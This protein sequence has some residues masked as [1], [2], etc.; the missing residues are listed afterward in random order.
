MN[1]L[2]VR[3][4]LKRLTEKER[5]QLLP[6]MGK[7]RFR[8]L[9]ELDD[10]ALMDALCE[11]TA[12]T[13]VR[14]YDKKTSGLSPEGVKLLEERKEQLRSP[15]NAIHVD[16]RQIRY[17]ERLKAMRMDVPELFKSRPEPKQFYRE[18][19]RFCRDNDIPEA[20][21]QRLVPAIIHYVETG[22]M[23]PVILVGEK[24]C[25]KTTALRL[26][27]EKALKLP[28]T[29]VKVPQLDG[30][31]GMTGDCGMYRSADAGCLAK[32][33]L[34]AGTL[35]HAFIFDEI[36]KV[37][38]DGNR[39]AV[40]DELLSV[41]DESC[42]DIFDNY[43]ETTLVGL[44]HCP[45]FF[46]ANDLNKVSP[47]LADRCEI[48]RF[49]NADAERIK[50]ISRKYVDKKMES[51]LYDLIRFDYELMDRHID[52][53]VRHNV[54]S[55]RKHQQMIEAVL[56]KVLTDALCS[57]EDVTVAVTED[58]FR[59]AETALLGVVKRRAGF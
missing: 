49:P 33:R 44:E 41:T 59:E 24:G 4:F 35:V 52:E 26:L 29:V 11:Y 18:L 1:E 58:M 57:D 9:L 36:D 30:S 17:L 31:H 51:S 55:L 43:L 2:D 20:F 8:A 42:T 53:L 12:Q 38:R 47:V 37:S 19:V 14:W 27:T 15:V 56:E 50:S 34:N 10:A 40:D 54:T 13:Q 3:A 39:A 25:G 21:V 28:T 22:H 5:R 23:R 48:I 45:M 7:E 6:G 32:A 46:T 16:R